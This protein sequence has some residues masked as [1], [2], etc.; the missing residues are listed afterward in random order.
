MLVFFRNTFWTALRMAVVA[1]VFV[2]PVAAFAMA[3]ADPASIG[4]RGVGF[5]LL[6]ALQRVG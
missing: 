2:G 4:G 5:I 3:N 6:M 1:T